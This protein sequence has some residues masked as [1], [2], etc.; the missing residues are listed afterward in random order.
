MTGSSRSETGKPTTDPGSAPSPSHPTAKT[1]GPGFFWQSLVFLILALTQPAPAASVMFDFETGSPL[2]ATHQG[3]PRNQ[4][5]GGVT[6][7]FT[8][9]F[10]V[11]SDSTTGWTLSLFFQKYLVASSAPAILDIRLSQFV[12]S[13]SFAFATSDTRTV[14]IPSYILL[15]AYTNSPTTPSLGSVSNNG[16]WGTDTLPMGTI[17]FTAATPFNWLRVQMAPGQPSS[18][19]LVDTI[20]VQTAGGSTCTVTT[21]SS[22]AGGGSASGG[23]IY[24]TGANVILTASAALNYAFL[25]WSESGVPV[26]TSAIYAFAASGDR[27]LVA[28]FTP[29]FKIITSSSPAAGGSTSGGGTYNS[30][31]NVTVQATA[32]NGYAFVNWTVI[33][34]SASTSVSYSFVA[35]SN[36]T[37]VANFLPVYAISTASSPPSGGSTTGGGNYLSG[38]NVVV[39]ATANPGSAFVNWTEAGVEVNTSN[40]YAFTASTNRTLVANFAPAFYIQTAAAPLF[41]GSTSGDGT[42]LGGSNVTVQATANPGFAFVD[43]MEGGVEVS[44]SAS[45][46]FPASSE[47]SLVANFVPAASPPLSLLLTPTNTVVISWP[48]PSTGFQLQHVTDLG[49]TPLVWTDAT[50]IAEVVGGENQVLLSPIVMYQFYRLFYHP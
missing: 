19:F 32:N 45:Y 14:E 49:S 39:Q 16:T 46:S 30:G 13:I 9:P 15:T 17:S 36:R 20:T 50:N 4:T 5:M 34:M 28:I 33:G 41:G 31:S 1:C 10:S 27:A 24:S 21:A 48:A 7:F 43:W 40:S 2:L 3:L 26:S 37:L 11:Q 6:A 25:N 8:G 22:P 18:L 23:A 35:V 12:T 47:R 38:S 42:Y 44:T 29:T